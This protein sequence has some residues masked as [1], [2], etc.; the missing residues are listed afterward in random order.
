MYRP[1]ERSKKVSLSLKFV[2]ACVAIA[3][4]CALTPLPASAIGTIDIQHKNGSVNSYRDVEIKVF[5]GSLFLTSDDGDGTIV[6]NRAACSY[7][8]QII[9]CL[10]TSAALV[11]DGKSQPLSLKRGTIYLNYTG[12]AQTLSRSTMKLPAN[13]VLV[14]LTTTNDTL[15]TVRGRL[16][17]VIKQ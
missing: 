14:A 10:P 8:G 4:C 15:I 7:Q 1:R 6:V 16:D 9:V 12:D 2:S 13:S 17:Q 11:Q 3:V 5:S